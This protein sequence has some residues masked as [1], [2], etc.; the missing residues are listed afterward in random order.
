MLFGNIKWWRVKTNATSLNCISTRALLIE[1]LSKASVLQITFVS[2]WTEVLVNQLPLPSLCSERPSL[3]RPSCCAAS[4]KGPMGASVGEERLYSSSQHWPS[5]EQ[6]CWVLLL[7]LV[8]NF[9]L[10][11]NWKQSRN[12]LERKCLSST[13]FTEEFSLAMKLQN[14]ALSGSMNF[15]S[16][17]EQYFTEIKSTPFF[18]PF[19]ST[20]DS[21]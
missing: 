2:K 4:K 19:S 18:H 7:K 17:P 8:G 14:L 10:S 11:R 1:L 12:N 16:L 15:E 13:S 9:T 21:S 20:D 5:S 3:A 6:G